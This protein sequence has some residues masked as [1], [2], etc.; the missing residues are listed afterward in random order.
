MSEKKKQDANEVLSRQQTAQPNPLLDL[1]KGAVAH[2]DT[3]IMNA[4]K[5]LTEDTRSDVLGNMPAFLDSLLE[6]GV[7]QAMVVKVQ[8]PLAGNHPEVLYLIYNEERD[9]MDHVRLDDPAIVGWF[10]G[11]PKMYC[12]ARLWIDGTLQLLHRTTEQDW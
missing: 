5:Y 9:L 2:M 1:L 6:C 8:A 12:N 3:T 11:E 7:S 4:G 10:N